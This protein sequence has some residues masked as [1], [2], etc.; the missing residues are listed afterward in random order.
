MTN[1]PLILVAGMHRSGTSLLG[2]LLQSA[3][4]ALPG[5]LISG[6]EHNPEGYFEHADITYLQEQ[7]LLSL[8]RWWPSANGVLP[9][10]ID[11]LCRASTHATLDQLRTLLAQEQARQ[12]EPW[13]IKDP[14]SSLLLPLWRRLAGELEIPL[15]LIL[16]VRHPA[17]VV[18]SLCRRDADAA[19]MTPQR[20]E[21]LWWHHNQT[22]LRHA[23]GLPLQVVDYSQWFS[24]G[25]GP[26]LQLQNLWRFCSLSPPDQ[27]LGQLQ[28][29]LAQIKPEHRHGTAAAA[30][31]PIDPRSEELYRD[32]VAGDLER[33]ASAVQPRRQHRPTKRKQ[34]LS[35]A[36]GSAE[37][38]ELTSWFDPHFYRRRYPD[39]ADLSEPLQHYQTHGWREGRQPHPLFDPGHYLQRCLEH[40]LA[41][42][43]GQ[44]P[45][46]HFLERGLTAGLMPTPLAQASWWEHRQG[47]LE[48]D[49]TPNLSDLHP[50][51]G[52]ALALA[53][54]DLAVAASLLRHWQ[55]HGFPAPDWRTI[56]NAASPWLRWPSN[57]PVAL[58]PGANSTLPVSSCGLPL[59]HWLSQGWLAALEIGQAE[60]TTP[61]QP[62]AQ[63]P[64]SRLHLMLLPPDR[65][66]EEA[67]LIAMGQNPGL[68]VADPDPR[69]CQIWRHLG[70][71]WM[72]LTIPSA[73]QLD[74]HLGAESWV[75]QA[76]T[77]LGLPSP[78]ALA[79]RRLLTLGSGGVAWDRQ[80]DHPD[81]WCLPGFDGLLLDDPNA[82]RSLASWLWHC[83]RQGL[84]LIRLCGDANEQATLQ[85]LC[86]LPIS[87]ICVDGL[88]PASLDWELNWRNEGQPPPA[89]PITVQP[90]ANV[91]WEKGKSQEGGDVAVVVSLY[92]YADRI[93]AALD[94]VAAQELRSLELIVVDDA[95]TDHSASAVQQ[96]L[97][98]HGQRF[99]RALFLQH[100]YNVGL[101]S[102][103]NTAFAAAKA[104]WCLVLDADNALL[105]GAAGELLAVAQ[106]GSDRLAVVHP[107][108]EQQVEQAD[109]ILE[110]AGL[111]STLSWQESLF[112]QRSEGNYI[113]AMALVRR[114]AWQTV[115]G[116]V[117]IPG[118]WEDFDFWCLL[119]EAGFHGALCPAVLAQYRC[120]AASMLHKNTHANVRR[121]SRLLQH[122]HCWLHLRL[123]QASF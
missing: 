70:Q 90:M 89:E 39:L 15:R 52:A 118:G 50:W 101:A 114:S 53:D 26:K 91:L 123:G 55:M 40:G 61:D 100:P 113:D 51:G 13:A 78:A 115:G 60:P 46:N 5:P 66:P 98:Q 33:A 1:A 30:T 95:S 43:A 11:W 81:R 29:C 104:G 58:Q 9:L 44:S 41:L 108:I 112:A 84:T 27:R 93:A 56:S 121:V 71:A 117:N 22:V 45:L 36:R 109:G 16:A 23:G 75:A 18:H 12:A 49:R 83:H 68:A 57:P 32:L 3:G 14:R 110:T 73:S 69:R 17:E 76:E 54:H 92:N 10:P 74:Q 120:H 28:H 59:D 42:P 119:I 48:P 20:A 105:P 97:E 47:R 37:Q 87:W 2:S 38:L 21:R 82:A 24:A 72:P 79:G 80:T 102:A 62:P 96:W 31:V 99:C 67:E 4:V 106:H 77:R 6:D 88:T 86:W 85:P 111:L 8:D 122:R 63:P 35:L 94:S 64:I 116:Y 103:R 7:L 34:L 25:E 19:G 107:L 65:L